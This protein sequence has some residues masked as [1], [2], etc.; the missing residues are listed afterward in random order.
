MPQKAFASGAAP[1][2][3]GPYPRSSFSFSAF[4]LKCWP[5]GTSLPSVISI[6]GYTYVRLSN[7]KQIKTPEASTP[8]KCSNKK[9]RKRFFG[10]LRGEGVCSKPNTL[11][12]FRSFILSTIKTQDLSVSCDF[13]VFTAWQPRSRQVLT[14]L[15]VCS[16][17]M[18]LT[19]F[20]LKLLKRSAFA[21][22]CS[23]MLWI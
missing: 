14:A 12:D 9:W 22:C 6:S 7:N 1:R 21:A 11:V 8:C 15:V 16:C 20:A 2:R 19:P 5:L 4:G 17:P 23:K 13:V 10:K 18:F 3:Y